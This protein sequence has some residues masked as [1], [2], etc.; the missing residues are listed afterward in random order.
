MHIP[1]LLKEAV[2]FLNIR[3]GD[4]VLDATLG[5]G[6]H[7][8]EI[9]ARVRPGGRLIAVDKDPGAITAARKHLGDREKDI[10]YICSDFKN[11]ADMLDK[12]RVEKI[13]SAIFDLGMSSFQLDD[14]S[15]GFSFRGEGALDMRYDRTSGAT[16]KDAVNKLSKKELEYILREYGEERYSGRIA[17]QICAARKK[18]E[19]RTTGELVEV[20]ENS[21]GTRYRRQR[22]HPAARTFQAIR[23][24]V[25]R[26]LDSIP[27]ALGETIHRLMPGGRLCVIAFH[28]LEDR[29]V[30]NIFRA[31]A[32]T[33][34]LRVLTKKPVRAATEE[35]DLNT[36]ARSAK[37]RAAER[38]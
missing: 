22:I 27:A 36:R 9:L 37:L 13:N 10:F 3:Q 14:D 23:I 31:G 7:A 21:V 17:T 30:K 8:G 5:G 6:G 16:A 12:I 33:G 2:D 24:Y 20:I 29:I 15:R 11:I 35:I 28:S 25:N 26:E 18:K 4:T 32:R 34:E 1:V 38:T 19:I